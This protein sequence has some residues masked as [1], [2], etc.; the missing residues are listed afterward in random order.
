MCERKENVR[1]IA[2][3]ASLSS[4]SLIIRPLAKTIYIFTFTFNSHSFVG[5]EEGSTDLCS[6]YSPR[7]PCRYLG[8]S[9]PMHPRS[10]ATFPDMFSQDTNKGL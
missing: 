10:L 3:G 9:E 4:M 7:P 8:V 6:A 5:E 1:N 2:F